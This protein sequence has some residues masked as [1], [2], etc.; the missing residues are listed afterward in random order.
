MNNTDCEITNASLASFF[1]TLGEC[2]DTRATVPL[3][4]LKPGVDLPSLA[5]SSTCFC[6][7]AAFAGLEPGASPFAPGEPEFCKP[8]PDAKEASEPPAPSGPPEP[9]EFRHEPAYRCV[10]KGG[11]PSIFYDD[12][13]DGVT[14]FRDLCPSPK[15]ASV[16]TVAN[17]IRYIAEVI[18]GQSVYKGASDIATMLD[19]VSGDLEEG[20]TRDVYEQEQDG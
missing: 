1:A 6:L 20:G 18:E 3:E 10:S 7:S 16:K 5:F 14:G 8:V 11:F 17:L 19:S 12:L 4:D 15:H 2:L 9:L 13:A